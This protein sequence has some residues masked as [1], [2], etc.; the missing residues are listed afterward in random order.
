MAGHKYVSTPPKRAE[1]LGRDAAAAYSPAMRALALIAFALL[2][3]IAA[4]AGGADARQNDARLDTLF[5]RLHQTTNLQEAQAIQ[6]AI[7]SIWFESGD[8]ETDRLLARGNAA[9]GAG[10]FDVALLQFNAVVDKD[11]GLAEGWNRRATL[12]FMVG[13]YEASIRDIEKTLELE[14]RHFG[15]LSGLGLVNIRLERFRAAIDAFRRAL[16]VNPHM[17]GARQNIQTIEKQ[18]QGE[19]I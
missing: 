12:Y 17:L 5:A 10:D 6:A 2:L 16:E 1:A 3:A 18:L 7:W 14:P 8:D 15:A 4:P 13:D 9:M 11:P 19:E